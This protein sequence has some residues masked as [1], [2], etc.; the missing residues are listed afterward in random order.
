[1][2]FGALPPEVNSARIYSGAGSSSLTAAASAWNQLAAELNSAANGYESII[3]RLSSEE[4][5]GPASASMADA[6]APYVDWMNTTAAQ[7]EQAATQA[8]EAAAAYENALAATVHPSEVSTNRSQ[9]QTLL[10]TNVLGQ[11]TPAIAATEANY[12]EMWAQD[13]AAMYGYAGQSATATQVTPFTA[14]QPVTNAAGEAGQAAAVG[15]AASTAGNSQ[16]SQLISAVQNALQSLSMSASTTSSTTAS[17]TTSPIDT[18]L[19]DLYS[20]FGLTY[21]SGEPIANLLAPW[22]TYVGAIQSSVAIPHFLTGFM[23]STVALSK[24][25]MPATAAAKAA[26][27]GAAAAAAGVPGVG[28]LG[29]GLLGGGPIAAGL[30]NAAAAGRL[31]V[32]PTWMASSPALN[33][34]SS[35]PINSVSAASPDLGGAGN[36]LGGMPLAGAGAGAGG[37]GPKYGFRP[38]IM[39]RPPSAG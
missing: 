6:V 5:L 4:W 16:T 8:R 35:I 18:I 9:L 36:L 13:A 14:P 39:A 32:P 19:S 12:G 20:A 26:S 31:S 25:A 1:M 23:N 30:G 21:K 33:P 15:Q 3:T 2:D 22:T 37:A 17:S 29:G 10:S 28:G 11:N 38:T 34:M 27:D 24:A 7:A